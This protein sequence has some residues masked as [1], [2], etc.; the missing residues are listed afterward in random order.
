M[1]K[2]PVDGLLRTELAEELQRQGFDIS[3]EQ[4]RKYEDYGL[5][6]PEK[7]ENRYRVYGREV[8]DTIKQ[9]LTMKMIGMS[10]KRIKDF[11]NLRKQII[12]SPIVL[13]GHEI[14]TGKVSYAD[15]VLRLGVVKEDHKADHQQLLDNVTRYLDICNEIDDR[16]DKADKILEIESRKNFEN[17]QMV[18]LISQNK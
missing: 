16:I 10:L 11:L 1:D 14:P 13:K 18:T 3:S 7:M 12:D 5:F 4:L 17:I 15:L 6:S 2:S 8:V 9:V